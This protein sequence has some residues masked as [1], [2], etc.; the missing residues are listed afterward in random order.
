MQ[1]TTIIVLIAVLALVA[2]ALVGVAF[3][4]LATPSPTV[5]PTNPTTAPWCANPNNGVSAPYCYNSTGT[6]I[7][8]P[9]GCHGYGAQ[10]T[11]QYQGGGMMGGFGRGMIGRGW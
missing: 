4:Q 3:A 9:A 7:G 2:A 1:K 6:N 8:Y 5:N 11:N 10:G